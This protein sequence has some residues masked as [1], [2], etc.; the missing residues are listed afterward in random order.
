MDFLALEAL[1]RLAPDYLHGSCSGVGCETSFGRVMRVGSTRD[2][3]SSLQPTASEPVRLRCCS[4]VW[5]GNVHSSI[6][7]RRPGVHC[8]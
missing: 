5:S 7:A 2:C 1:E 4:E 6:E 3:E 8:G